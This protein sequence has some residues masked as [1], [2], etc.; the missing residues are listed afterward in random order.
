[1]KAEQSILKNIL[2]ITKKKEHIQRLWKKN[3]LAAPYW[4][5]HTPAHT[6][7]C[8]P[9]LETSSQHKLA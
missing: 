5:C 3:I 7:Y 1:M 9:V 4:N 2:I 8:G 6:P